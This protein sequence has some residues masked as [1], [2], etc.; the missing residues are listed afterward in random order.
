MM[1]PSLLAI[2]CLF[3]A[4]RS[5]RLSSSS[6]NLLFIR[7]FDKDFRSTAIFS[8]FERSQPIE[9]KTEEAPLSEAVAEEVEKGLSDAMKEKLRRELISQG[10]DPNYSAGPI[11][12]NPILLIS[13]VIAI[14][15]I[16][17]GKDVFY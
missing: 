7:N 14:L 6:R 13:G 1:L 12:G 11:L 10:A 15:V 9:K 16:L 5:Y 4:V 2:S 3:V 17:G 8:E